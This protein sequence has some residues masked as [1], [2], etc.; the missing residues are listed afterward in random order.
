M[1]STQAFTP[2]VDAAHYRFVDYVRRPRWASIWHQARRVLEQEPGSVVEVGGGKGYL[3]HLLRSEGVRVERVDLDVSLK[4]DTLADVREL[5]FQ[6]DAFDVA[7]A[8]EVLEHLP[9]EEVPS[10]LAELM[11]VARKAVVISVPDDRRAYPF[12]VSLPGIGRFRFLLPRW[13]PRKSHTFDGEH[14]WEI[15]TRQVPLSRFL[16]IA[17]PLPMPLRAQGLCVDNPNHRFFV[18]SSSPPE[19]L[20]GQ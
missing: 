14:Y 1:S 9:F 13:M 3:A 16:R 19:S 2:Q 4:P 7:C 8:F 12:L 17:G 18:F 6:D 11:R 5:P 10:A 20:V 15:N